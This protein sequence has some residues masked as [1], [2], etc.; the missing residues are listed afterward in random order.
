MP[1]KWSFFINNITGSVSE[2]PDAE[3]PTVVEALRG[4]NQLCTNSA[5]FTLLCIFAT[6]LL[7]TATR[8]S[9][10]SSLKY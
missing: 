4:G 1:L 5:V 3:K 6:L 2:T 10:F 8:E 9:S 7:T